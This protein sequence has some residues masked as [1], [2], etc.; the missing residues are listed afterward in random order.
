MLSLTRMPG[1]ATELMIRKKVN[2]IRRPAGT[3]KQMKESKSQSKQADARTCHSTYISV[4]RPLP[5]GVIGEP[6]HMKISHV[7]L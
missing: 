4:Y 2:G 5:I 6:P 3:A 1:R 7:T